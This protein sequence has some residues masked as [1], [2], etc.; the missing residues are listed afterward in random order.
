LSFYIQYYGI[1]SCCTYDN[2]NEIPKVYTMLD[3][4]TN[5]LF[6]I[7]VINIQRRYTM[8]INPIYLLPCILILTVSLFAQVDPGTQN[9]THS[10]TFEDGTA[11]DYV[12]GANGYLMGGAMIEDGA[13]VTNEPGQYLDLVPEYVALNT[14]D[15]FTCEIW[16]QSFPDSNRNYHMFFY[17]GDYKD[18]YGY[19]GYFM[20]PARGDNVSRAAISCWTDVP[21]Q[22]ESGANGPECDDG[23][24][25]HMVSTLDSKEITLYIDGVET[26]RNTLL[27]RNT[28]D[29]LGLVHCYLSKSGYD[30]DATW[31]GMIMECN[32]YDRVLTSDEILFLAQKGPTVGTEENSIASLP[33]E[34]GLLQNY[35]NPFNPST[36]ISFNLQRRSRIRITV[37]NMLGQ[38]VAELLND[39]RNKGLSS[40]QFDGSNLSSGLY[41]YKMQIDNQ[42]IFMKKMMLSK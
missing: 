29:A 20:T 17:F 7:P 21:Y 11:N 22:G 38:Q 31:E 13:L 28:I 33:Q 40:I 1:F 12:G 10:W 3:Y 41:L 14:Y 37:Y 25:H 35:P 36:T 4:L 23:V 39:D 42:Q 19:N 34:Y 5:K 24:L 26:G 2:S 30:G 6:N 18:T 16:F 32:I 15:A 9:L 8:N 27:E